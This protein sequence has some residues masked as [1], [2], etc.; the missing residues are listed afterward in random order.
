[1]L[2][3]TILM[4]RDQAFKCGRCGAVA[5]V[6]HIEAG[7]LAHPPPGWQIITL[8]AQDVDG[9]ARL[10]QQ[11]VCSRACG[12]VLARDG[13]AELAREVMHLHAV[14]CDLPVFG[15][16]GKP[17]PQV[18]GCERCQRDTGKQEPRIAEVR[19]LYCQLPLSILADCQTSHLA[20]C[21]KRPP[22]AA[23]EA[24]EAHGEVT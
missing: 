15:P 16:D 13:S 18:C 11:P 9:A 21:G 20:T 1:M 4:A 17:A 2:M 19:C 6:A 3:G 22:P 14:A 10:S 12:E 24:P 8:W 23:P 7:A 5:T